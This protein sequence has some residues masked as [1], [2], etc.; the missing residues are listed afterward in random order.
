M[1]EMLLLDEM[2]CILVSEN[3]LFL[4]CCRTLDSGEVVFCTEESTQKSND[5]NTSVENVGPQEEGDASSKN[6]WW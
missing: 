1:E 2:L 4:V 6:G 5:S 3:I